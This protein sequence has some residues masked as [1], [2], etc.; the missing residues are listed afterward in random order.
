MSTLFYLGI[1]L[2]LLHVILFLVC[3]HFIH[4]HVGENRL[5]LPG[6]IKLSVTITTVLHAV[7]AT[8]NLYLILTSSISIVLASL[9]VLVL[10]GINRLL[11]SNHFRTLDQKVVWRIPIS[12]TIRSTIAYLLYTLPY[13]LLVLNQGQ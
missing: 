7:I 11:E 8:L 3:T 12:F 2:S 4:Q 9:L 1:I 10:I 6:S 13:I 5:T